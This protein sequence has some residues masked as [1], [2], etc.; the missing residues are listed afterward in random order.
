MENCGQVFTSIAKLQNTSFHVAERAKND[1]KSAKV[2]NSRAKR[3]KLLVFG[4]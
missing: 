2:K 4:C 3:A 1:A